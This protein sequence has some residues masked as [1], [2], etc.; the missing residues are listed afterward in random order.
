MLTISNT[1]MVRLHHTC[2]QFYDRLDEGS[3]WEWS[4]RVKGERPITVTMYKYDLD[5]PRRR[6][7]NLYKEIRDGIHDD[8]REIV[9]ERSSGSKKSDFE[10][11][12]RDITKDD[13]GI[14]MM[15]VTNGMST[16]L[17]VR[18]LMVD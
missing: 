6:I 2:R 4:F 1:G 17:E 5:V 9:K 15:E 14:Y 12:M 11:I 7:R 13:E 18:G 10:M 8:H 16:V 3:D